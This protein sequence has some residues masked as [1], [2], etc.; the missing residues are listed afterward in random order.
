MWGLPVKAP[1]AAVL[2]NPYRQQWPAFGTSERAGLAIENPRPWDGALAGLAW[3]V[4]EDLSQPFDAHMAQVEPPGWIGKVVAY[5]LMTPTVRA[6]VWPL[7]EP[8]EHVA[9]PFAELLAEEAADEEIRQVAV[10]DED[11]EPFEA[12][13]RTTTEGEMRS[14]WAQ[15]TSLPDWTWEITVAALE[16]VR[17]EPLERRLR[18]ALRAAL[19]AVP[20]ALAVAEEDRETLLMA[21]A[22]AGRQIIDALTGVVDGMADE[23]RRYYE[24]L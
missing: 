19:Q 14:V 11:G 4:P 18:S 9:R 13:E 6:P 2:G 24:A 15:K 10:D 12:W 22:P 17:E 7:K 1:L 3:H 8:P 5:Q 21:G 23:L 16:F 20:G